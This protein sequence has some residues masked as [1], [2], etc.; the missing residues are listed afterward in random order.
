MNGTERMIERHNA[1]TYARQH[2]KTHLAWRKFL[3]AGGELPCE[4]VG[5]L[6]HHEEAIRELET[7]YAALSHC[8]C[9]SEHA[10]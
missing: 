5:D 10:G 2:L 1:L 6:E 9:A 8:T 4:E 7:I 3:K